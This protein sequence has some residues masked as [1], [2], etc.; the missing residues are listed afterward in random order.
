LALFETRG[1]A[2]QDVVAPFTRPDYGG[3]CT[4]LGQRRGWREDSSHCGSSNPCCTKWPV[5]S[6]GKPFALRAS[7]RGSLPT[8]PANPRSSERRNAGKNFGRLFRQDGS[9]LHLAARYQVRVTNSARPGLS[10]CASPAAIGT[11]QLAGCPTEEVTLGKYR[12]LSPCNVSLR[13]TEG[14]NYA[15]FS[16]RRLQLQKSLR[17]K[18]RGL[19]TA[20][21]VGTKNECFCMPHWTPRGSPAVGSR[22]FEGQDYADFFVCL[23]RRAISESCSSPKNCGFLAALEVGTKNECFCMP[24]WTHRGSPALGSRLVEGQDYAEFFGCLFRRAI[25]H[26]RSS[27]KNCGLLLLGEGS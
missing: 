3:E 20:L 4:S 24:H 21:E 1:G 23:F 11:H 12:L 6:P 26:S 25:S 19:S 27:P 14:Q 9:Q 7:R 16:C 22:L 18:S 13:L 10:G 15:G 17:P 8:A 5:P 2:D